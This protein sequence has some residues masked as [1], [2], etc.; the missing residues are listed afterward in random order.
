METGAAVVA[1]AV[2]TSCAAE[3]SEGENG[4]VGVR[5]GG[6]AVPGDD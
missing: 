1:V 2:V 3:V 4:I 5:A 6:L